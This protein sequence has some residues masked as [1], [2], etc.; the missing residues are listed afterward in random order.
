MKTFLQPA[1]RG[2]YS[3]ARS[4]AFGRNFTTAMLRRLLA[5]SFASLLLATPVI[6]ADLGDDDDDLIVLGTPKVTLT[7]PPANSVYAAPATISLTASASAPAVP[8]QRVDYFQGVT[9]IGSATSA[10]YNVAWSSVPAGIYSLTARA[11]STLGMS[12]TSAPVQVRV[13]GIP[14]TAI[15]APVGG[16]VVG[17]GSSVSLQASAASPAGACA[18]TKVE[19]YGQTTGGP[20]LLGTSIGQGPYNVT[21]TATPSGV[22]T[23]TAVAYDERSVTATSAPVVV[24]VEPAPS[25]AITSPTNGAVFTPPATIAIGAT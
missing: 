21:W 17:T 16:T 10:P 9:L 8:I 11:K 6:A 2:H 5:V 4:T 20:V 1:G 22:Y 19:F 18:I 15:T 14:V 12:G 13:C 3:R 7:A 24:T 23:L 25:V